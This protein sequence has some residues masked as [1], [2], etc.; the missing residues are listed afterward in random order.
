M[1]EGSAIRQT[2]AAIV[3]AC[4]K[5]V[6]GFI[7]FF[8]KVQHIRAA[9]S[10]TLPQSII[11]VFPSIPYSRTQKLNFIASFCGPCGSLSSNNSSDSLRRPLLS[12]DN[13]FQELA[14]QCLAHIAALMCIDVFAPI[15]ARLVNFSLYEGQFLT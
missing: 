6:S 4:A 8:D 2:T 3:S 5:C 1:E 11:I 15:L 7:N 13:A 10:S 12:V 14:A 9:I